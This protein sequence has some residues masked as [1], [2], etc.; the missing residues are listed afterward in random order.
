[1][2]SL[3]YTLTWCREFRFLDFI[4]FENSN[5]PGKVLIIQLYFIAISL[6]ISFKNSL[7]LECPYILLLSPRYT[8]KP[9][10]FNW[11]PCMVN[12][13]KCPLKW[14][15]TMVHPKDD[16]LSF[17]KLAGARFAATGYRYGLLK[18]NFF[19]EDSKI[20]DCRADFRLKN[21]GP[22][23]RQLEDN[24]Q[25]RGLPGYTLVKK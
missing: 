5:T 21:R 1:M 20:E 7:H 15:S 19:I 6:D 22:N 18:Y 10:V 14:N 11:H 25:N 9:F 3:Q 4:S 24:R 23:Q 13:T 16:P 8:K 12:R 17:I 2:F